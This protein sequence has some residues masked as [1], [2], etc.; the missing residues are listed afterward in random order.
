[1][2]LVRRHLVGAVMLV[3]ALAI[4]IALGGG[5]LSHESLLP[6]S[7][8]QA[9][10]R[11]AQEASG[12]TGDDVAAAAAADLYGARLE[13]RTVA[14]LSAPGAERGTLDA[15]AKGIEAADGSVSAR[16]SAGQGLVGAGEK[17]L[18]DTLGSQLVEQLD[19]RGADPEA[20]AYVRMGQ[21]IGTAIASRDPEGAVPG[22]EAMTIR[23]SI[24]AASL[25]SQDGGEPR[26]APLV[27]LVLGDN[28]DDNIVEGL[29]TGLASRTSGLVVAAPGRDSDLSTIAEI[30]T[31]TTVDGVSGATGRLAA[32]LALA[33]TE[34]DPGGSFGAS[35]AD[36]VLP[37]G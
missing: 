4:G 28:L 13:G 30:G 1:M 25:L 23:Q 36:G 18:V 9:P 26:Q 16:W 31:V 15:L 20:S 2:T 32:V 37:L 35:G 24:G 33:R 19:G 17:A 3:M 29:V 27:L 22:Q 5:P 11:A 12:P 8:P 10:P 34:E 6:S 14:L 21:L 7:A